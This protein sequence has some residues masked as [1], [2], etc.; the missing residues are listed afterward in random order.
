MGKSLTEEWGAGL[1]RPCA[2]PTCFSWGP[3]ALNLP[4]EAGPFLVLRDTRAPG[5]PVLLT[6][7]GTVLGHHELITNM[8]LGTLSV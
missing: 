8:L 7:T 5:S 6:P 2:V 4:L 3:Q 1:P